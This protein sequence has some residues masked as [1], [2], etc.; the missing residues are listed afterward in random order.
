MKAHVI[1]NGLVVNTIVV[2]SLDFLPNLVSAEDGGAIGDR[3][4]N[5]QFVTPQ[6]VIVAPTSVTMRQGRLA[7]LQAGLL[8]QVQSAIDAQS[9]AEKIEWEYAQTIDRGSPLVAALAAALSLDDAALDA[10][11]INAANL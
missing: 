9:D 11:F 8:T 7:L 4:E 1:E 2:D 10:L 3:Y 5:G 6:A